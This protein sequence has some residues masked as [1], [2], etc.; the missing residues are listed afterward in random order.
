[1][2]TF[3]LIATVLLAMTPQVQV[4]EDG[5]LPV[6]SSMTTT[7]ASHTTLI[8]LCGSNLGPAPG[9][10]KVS[11]RV[12]FEQGE[13]RAVID[14][15]GSYGGPGFLP[16]AS[17]CLTVRVPES[18][19]MGP[20]TVHIERGDLRSDVLEL[21]ITDWEPPSVTELDADDVPLKGS[22]QIE[23]SGFHVDDEAELV[24]GKGRRFVLPGGHHATSLHITLPKRA[25]AGDARVRI[26]RQ[27]TTDGAKTEWFP[28][29]IVRGPAPPEFSEGW[30]QPQMPGLWTEPIVGADSETTDPERT[31]VLFEQS[32][33]S[34]VSTV[35]GRETWRVRVPEELEP[36]PATLRARDFRRGEWS[37][38]SKREPFT[39]RS[40]P[41]TPV[42][43]GVHAIL[44]DRSPRFMVAGETSIVLGDGENVG[45]FGLFFAEAASDYVAVFEQGTERVEIVCD[46][47]GTYHMSIRVAGRLGEGAWT[48]AI[49]RRAD[50]F[51]LPATRSV[52]VPARDGE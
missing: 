41:A 33:V 5:P 28:F 17:D 45:V 10:R 2:P 44:P 8:G 39:V 18:I 35:V 14:E 48:L 30:T 4:A 47:Y 12:V 49:V 24:D 26:V 34:I 50:G 16:G 6:L 25:E 40:D 37:V 36:G 11:A 1:M 43:G 9:E 29:R 23:G 31:E 19:G 52:V 15:P 22:V 3:T 32:D 42:L 21:T 20:C 38:W 51:R 27:G 46:D 13:I 7:R